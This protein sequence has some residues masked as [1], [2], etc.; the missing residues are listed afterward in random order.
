MKKII[1]LS[2]IFLGCASKDYTK[3]NGKFDELMKQS[4]S[5]LVKSENINKELDSLSTVIVKETTERLDSL[6]TTVDSVSCEA[7]ALKNELSKVTKVVR[8]KIIYRTDTVFIEK[9]KNIWGKEKTNVHVNSDSLIS[10]SED[11]LQ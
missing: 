2:L 11:T 6:I 3:T 7:Q 8:E 5:S 10:N 4:D 1:L 9:R